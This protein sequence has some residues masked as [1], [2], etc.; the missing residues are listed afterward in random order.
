[1]S[2][3]DLAKWW[4]EHLRHVFVVIGA[5]MKSARLYPEDLVTIPQDIGAILPDHAVM[6]THAPGRELKGRKGRYVITITGPRF[7]GR[8][9]FSS[10]ELERL[11]SDA[12]KN[13]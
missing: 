3:F 4:P 6:V 1:M 9:T 13:S 11:A 2:D 12:F 10:G 8:W 5:A 7:G